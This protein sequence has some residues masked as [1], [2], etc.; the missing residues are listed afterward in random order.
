MRNFPARVNFPHFLK[1][2]FFTFLVGSGFVGVAGHHSFFNPSYM[3]FESL[4][5][6]QYTLEVGSNAILKGSEKLAE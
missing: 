6:L 1:A 2:Y 3:S 4:Q 5:H